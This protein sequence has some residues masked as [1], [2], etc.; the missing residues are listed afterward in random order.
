[1][2]TCPL[3]SNLFLIWLRL[4]WMVGEA[5]D[6]RRRRLRS[7]RLLSR[8]DAS[9]G[10]KSVLAILKKDVCTTPECSHRHPR[11]TRVSYLKGGQEATLLDHLVGSGEQRGRDFEVQLFGGFEVNHQLEFGG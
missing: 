2:R 1:M 3:N 6:V 5:L 8:A 7:G 10:S 11:E 9:L 4:I